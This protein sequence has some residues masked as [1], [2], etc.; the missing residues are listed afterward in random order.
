[1]ILF[2]KKLLTAVIRLVTIHMSPPRGAF[3]RFLRDKPET[4]VREAAAFA[5]SVHRLLFTE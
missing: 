1:M 5:S 3:T 4:D 2:R